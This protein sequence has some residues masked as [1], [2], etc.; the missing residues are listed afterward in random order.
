MRQMK[1]KAT[2]LMEFA[3]ARFPGCANWYF[4][5]IMVP[6]YHL[7]FFEVNRWNLKSEQQATVF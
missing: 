7:R 1:N 5:H 3:C 4:K 2:H 6:F